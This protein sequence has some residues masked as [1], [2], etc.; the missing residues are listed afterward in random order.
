MQILYILATV[1]AF[2]YEN[3]MFQLYMSCLSR[4]DLFMD[5]FISVLDDYAASVIVKKRIV[6]DLKVTS[7]DI[8][9]SEGSHILGFAK[10]SQLIYLNANVGSY[11]FPKSL[12]KQ[13]VEINDT[14]SDIYVEMIDM[15]GRW[16]FEG[17]NK[18]FKLVFAHEIAHGLGFIS[19][20]VTNGGISPDLSF[21]GVPSQEQSIIFSQPTIFDHFISCGDYQLSD[22]VHDY[23]VC[24]TFSTAVNRDALKSVALRYIDKYTQ[25]KLYS[26]LSTQAACRFKS[27]L[28]SFYVY[29]ADD[30]TSLN[31]NLISH[32]VIVNDSNPIPL[33]NAETISTKYN[34][35][36][37]VVPVLSSM[38]YSTTIN[39][40]PAIANVKRIEI[41]C[42]R[43]I[44]VD[45][46]KTELPEVKKNQV[47][48]I[49]TSV[50]YLASMSFIQLLPHVLY[51]RYFINIFDKLDFIK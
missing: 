12:A 41:K 4:C 18:D 50:L 16:T 17:G 35:I 28:S 23:D 37:S 44:N 46:A 48:W 13:F 26:Y 34:G 9:E 51:R 40:I 39:P 20:V 47:R 1:A 36:Q 30:V 21:E 11:L 25:K 7:L 29:T 19:S 6:I 10:P 15:K 31:N 43:L 32:S 38:G 45:E 3:K 42:K 33:M 22:F 27:P 49:L 8:I 24:A 14:S 5:K 2:V